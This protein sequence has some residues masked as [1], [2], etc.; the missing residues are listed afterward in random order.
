MNKILALISTIILGTAVPASAYFNPGISER[1]WQKFYGGNKLELINLCEHQD[2][3]EVLV[4]YETSEGY[5]DADEY[6]LLPGETLSN[7]E[8][9]NRFIYVSGESD[10]YM[11]YMQ[12][13]DFDAYANDVW[14]E[15][16]CD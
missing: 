9:E 2:F 5:Y 3:V 15:F 4:E 6:R 14:I 16:K 8:Y 13:I 7:L 12:E 11:W 10:E 1:T